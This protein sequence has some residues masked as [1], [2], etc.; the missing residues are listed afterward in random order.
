MILIR[1]GKYQ[2]G[3]RLCDSFYYETTISGYSIALDIKL[4]NGEP[5][6]P[7]FCRSFS[8]GYQQNSPILLKIFRFFEEPD[9]SYQMNKRAKELREK[10]F[11]SL[12][13]F[14]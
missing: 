12:T 3:L 1:E 10:C 7:A 8:N 9:L 13:E 6:P 5:I 11:K 2:E 4:K 14:E